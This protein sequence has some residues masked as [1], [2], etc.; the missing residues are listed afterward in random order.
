MTKTRT[1]I[2]IMRS[3]AF[4]FT[5]F[6]I[7]SLIFGFRVK[8]NTET[9]VNNIKSG[10]PIA[11]TYEDT[12]KIAD[13]LNTLLSL[14]KFPLVAQI[15][16]FANLDFLPDKKF[17]NSI[18]ESTPKLVG[19]DKPKRYLIAFQNS[20]E[21]RGTGG[22]IGAFAVVELS[23]GNISVIK[24]GSNALLKSL[25]E[26]PI[27][28]PDEYDLLYRSDP[29]IWQNSN[30]SPHYPYGAK[31]WLALWKNQYGETLDGVVAIDPSALSYVLKA[32]GP[33][34]LSTGEKISS[35][36]VVSE[37]LEKA[38]K[39][40]EKDNSAREAYLVRI[41]NATAAK[42]VKGHFSKLEM[43][44]AIFKGISENRILIYSSESD[45]Q[46]KLAAVR[47]GGVLNS[48]PNNEFRTV[49]INTDASKLDYYLSRTTNVRSIS[50]SSEPTVKVMVT[51]KNSL[52]SGVGL[53][54][55]VL[56]RADQTRPVG[57]IQGQHRFLALIYGPTSSNL[58]SARRSSSFGSPGGV[59]SERNRPLLA[60]DVDLAPGQSEIITAEFS[61]G[62]GPITYHAQPL[63]LREKVSI[64]DKCS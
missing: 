59:G 14:A 39:K 9:F 13:D 41:I 27:N 38:Y 24:T 45:V 18:I 8:N 64:N 42:L 19:A 28:M 35:K 16:S 30:I 1:F 7:I 55:Y 21:A 17:V 40:Y 57:I 62:E 15:L 3:S 20:A 29:A 10:A 22:I 2:W 50:C 4:A 5:V 61:R 32:T 33:I 46:K 58:L 26:I 44:R 63:V 23:R 25:E 49:I 11:T 51:L 47:I 6:L 56:T 31:I 53:P 52:K 37:T 60:V 43:A 48:T 54:R 34:T 12:R 36:N